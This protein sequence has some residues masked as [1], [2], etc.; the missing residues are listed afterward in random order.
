ME[1][2]NTLFIFKLQRIGFIYTTI[3][4]YIKKLLA[5]FKT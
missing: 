5:E 1:I 2:G 3:K 4:N